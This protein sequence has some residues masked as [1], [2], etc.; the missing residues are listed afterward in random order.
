MLREQINLEIDEFPVV[1]YLPD[2]GQSDNQVNTM[3]ED[4]YGFIWFGTKNSLVRYDGYEYKVYSIDNLGPEGFKGWYI[5]DIAED[6]KGDI[7]VG[8]NFGINKLSRATGIF[9]FYQPDPKNMDNPANLIGQ[10][11]FDSRGKLW[12]TTRKNVLCLDPETGKFLTL[13][14]DSLDWMDSRQFI[15]NWGFAVEDHFAEDSL[16]RLWIATINGL[17]RY[18][19]TNNLTKLF[20]NDKND[21]ASIS[22]NYITALYTDKKGRLWITTWGGGLN[23]LLDGDKGVFQ[24]IKLNPETVKNESITY[25]MSLYTSADPDIWIAGRRGITRFNTDTRKSQS[26]SFDSDWTYNKIFKDRKDGFWLWQGWNLKKLLISGKKLV[27]VNHSPLPSNDALQD[28]SGSIWLGSQYSFAFRVDLQTPRFRLYKNMLMSRCLFEDSRGVIW[29]SDKGRDTI[30]GYAISKLVLDT[31][32]SEIHKIP[33]DFPD[34]INTSICMTEDSSG[35]QWFVGDVLRKYDPR[36]RT[37]KIFNF[38]AELAQK[39]IYFYGA[40][41]NA[42]QNDNIWIGGPVYFLYEFDTRTEKFQAKFPVNITSTDSFDYYSVIDMF[43]DRYN[44]L[45]VATPKG[46]LKIDIANGTEERYRSYLVNPESLSDDAP[47]RIVEDNLGRLWILCGNTGLCLYNRDKKTFYDVP[48]PDQLKN[49][50]FGDLAKDKNGNFWITHTAGFSRFNPIDFTMKSYDLPK[51]QGGAEVY[52]LRSGELF[53]SD[54]SEGNR[55]YRFHVDSINSNTHIPPVWVSKMIVNN[56]EIT[57]I[58]E[59][60]KS[61]EENTLR[62]KHKE[63]FIS[64]EFV[65]LNYTEAEKNQYRYFLSGVNRDTVNSGTWRNAE[66]TNLSPGKYRFWVTG[67]NND[68]LWNP[69]GTSLSFHIYPPWYTTLLAKMVYLI[70]FIGGVVAIIKWRINNLLREKMILEAEVIKRTK[71]IEEQKHDIEVQQEKLLEMD[72]YKT[73][74]FT[75]ISHEFRSPLTIILG[76]SDELPDSKNPRKVMNEKFKIIWRNAKRL[77]GLVN[78]LLDLS[79]INSNKMKLELIETDVIDFL[80]TVAASFSS[81]AESKMID[82]CYRLPIVN[83][84][85]YCDPD[86]LEKILVNLLSN[87]FKFTTNGGKITV[88]AEYASSPDSVSEFLQLSVSDTGIGISEKDQE[89]IFDRFYQAEEHI[90]AAKGGT[91]IGLSLV[92]D[93]INLMHGKIT[94]KSKP[95][96]GS[97]FSISIPLGINHLTENEYLIV[98]T[99]AGTTIE[100]SNLYSLLESDKENL[101]LNIATDKKD[102]PFI[103]IVEDNKDIR[104]HISENFRNHYNVLEANDGESGLAVALREMPDLI[105]TDLMMPH[106]NGIELCKKLKTDERTS[107]IPVIMLTAKADIDDKLHGLKT[108]ADDY[109]IKPF[110]MKELRVRVKNLVELRKKLRERFSREITLEPY[111][112]TITPIDEEF[113]KKA[114]SYVE[115]HISESGY[116]VEHFQLDMNMSRSTLSRKIHALTNYSPVEFIRFIRLKRAANLLKQRFGNVTEVALEVGFNS[117]SYFA[118]KFKATF[119]ISPFKYAK[120]KKDFQISYNSFS[121]QLSRK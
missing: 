78:Q 112:I 1:N 52:S 40:H 71:Q 118:K 46:L 49:V 70:L 97:T 37:S 104:I 76:L 2:R 22:N 29:Y 103:L 25:L 86:K 80:R 43:T 17:I 28:R 65:S 119:G 58:L 19:R 12:A 59:R 108:G 16:N 34:G 50:S 94:L 38:P 26:Y 36:T 30:R 14:A 23:L 11:Y 33:F 61:I 6:K 99:S 24:Q 116:E 89:K 100:D 77:L 83:K 93:L 117:P 72:E 73:R 48:L 92:K 8:T 120:D 41:I 60:Q 115:L 121:L 79:K 81:L 56:K 114:I 62:L 45:W 27:E 4:N 85:H 84:L 106:M 31:N 13:K 66:F 51:K 44:C 18:D 57:D 75:N 47:S 54:H 32:S 87:A 111:D 63:N 3:L 7:W 102:N 53:I 5:R 109:L 15:G 82:Y 21:P 35:F 64:F 20:V 9:T 96:S 10:L 42:D 105:I 91:G 113:L 98:N 68:G 107:H 101:V 39:I 95:G 110:E 74:F 90:K 88:E 55:V 67:S 69:V